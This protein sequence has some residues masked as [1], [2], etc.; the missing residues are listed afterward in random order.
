MPTQENQDI[1]TPMTE[2]VL[3]APPSRT[4]NSQVDNLE[5][6]PID[7]IPTRA[8]ST[9]RWEGE[10]EWMV[11]PIRKKRGV[12]RYEQDFLNIRLGKFT[13]EDYEGDYDSFYFF[14][15]YEDGEQASSYEEVLKRTYKNQWLEAMKSEMKSLE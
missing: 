6:L 8:Y 9:P 2:D 13:L 12:V 7:H 4:Q 10:E 3:R 5:D 1:E 14:S 15:A 11:R